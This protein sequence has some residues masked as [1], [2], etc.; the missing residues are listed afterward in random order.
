MTE[1]YSIWV[2]IH[3]LE[4]LIFEDIQKP[5]VIHIV[6]I[7][8]TKTPMAFFTEVDKNPKLWKNHKIP[9]IAKKNPE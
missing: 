5:K 3:G 7:M 9:Q 1:L 6:D 4:E 2:H 8:P